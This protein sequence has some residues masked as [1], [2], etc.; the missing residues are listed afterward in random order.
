[1]TAADVAVEHQ[2]A[3][4]TTARMTASLVMARW[5]Q[6]DSGDIVASW[7]E[8]IPQVAAQVAAAQAVTAQRGA[9][10]TAEAV[11]AQGAIPEP[12]GEVKTV[13]LAGVASD[14]R[15]LDTLL[16]LPGVQTVGRIA[17]GQPV[18]QAMA[19][20]SRTVGL[21]AA[22]QVQD[23]GRAGE[24]VALVA[25]R[26]VSGYRRQLTTPS[27]GRC[28]L[29]AG[30]WFRWNRGFTRHPNCDCVHV[31]AVGPKSDLG[32]LETFDP[33][34]YFDSLTP[35]QQDRHFTKSG[36]QAIR[37]GADIGQVVNARRGMKTTVAYGRKISTTTVGTSTRASA[38]RRMAAELDAQFTKQG[39]R[40]RRVNTPRLMPEAI[41]KEAR[42]REDAIRLLRRFGYL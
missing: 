11:R 36:A 12:V 18:R 24:S 41:Y 23:A 29:L 8:Q 26:T 13:R 14:G 1:M 10:Y 38:A 42:D 4:Q 6:V 30:K 20:G 2:T 35:E 39:G 7:A 25:D 15:P 19:Q 31:P 40:Y 28:A 16:S 5:R 34:G 32:G 33:K 22:T 27:C 21:L 9:S 3:Q 17:A 37:D